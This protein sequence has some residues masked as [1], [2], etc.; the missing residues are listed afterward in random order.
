MDFPTEQEAKEFLVAEIVAEACREGNPLSE[1]ERKM[2]YFTESGWTLSDMADVA[3][4][5]DRENEQEYEIKIR[6]LARSARK[7]LDASK[8]KAWSSAVKR[9]GTGDHYLLVMLDSARAD[10]GLRESWRLPAVICG[11]TFAFFLCV[12]AYLGHSPNRAERGS[13]AWLAIAASALAYLLGR[14]VFGRE[15]VE[16][17]VDRLLDA[18]LL[19]RHKCSESVGKEPHNTKRRRS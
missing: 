1:I 2:L 5:F 12:S 3:A 15:A 14:L 6:R 7:Q 11:G 9:L 19:G 17:F 18:V 8:A 16:R 13:L 4:A 10:G